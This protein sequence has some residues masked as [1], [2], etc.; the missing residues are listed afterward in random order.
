M[1]AE[2]LTGRVLACVVDRIEEKANSFQAKMKQKPAV[3][4]MPPFTI[5]RTSLR[6]AYKRE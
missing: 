1:A 3:A 6:K 5:G 2:I 4:A